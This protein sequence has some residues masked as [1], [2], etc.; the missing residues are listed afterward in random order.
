VLCQETLQERR[1][2]DGAPRPVFGRGL[3]ENAARSGDLTSAISYGEQALAGERKSL[4]SL[5]MVS[6]ELAAV[7]RQ[8]WPGESETAEYADRLRQLA[9]A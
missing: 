9:T 1:D 3:D 4:P 5:L 6:Q 7:V 2:V 8:R